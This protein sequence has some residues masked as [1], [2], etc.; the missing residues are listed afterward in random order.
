MLCTTDRR[1]GETRQKCKWSR[2]SKQ[3][4]HTQHRHV[5]LSAALQAWQEAFCIQIN[6]LIQVNVCRSIPSYITG[7]V[8]INNTKLQN[9]E[10]CNK[11]KRRC[12]HG[13]KHSLKNRHELIIEQTQ[14]IK[15]GSHICFLSGMR[16]RKIRVFLDRQDL[17]VRYMLR[18][19]SALL[20]RRLP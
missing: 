3:Y 20:R 7:N 12:R 6:V 14:T 8:S 13:M 4:R 1:I 16:R 10:T 15:R 19:Y 11:H 2:L 5:Q 9:K 18:L 17:L